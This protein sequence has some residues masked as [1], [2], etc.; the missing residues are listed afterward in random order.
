MEKWFGSSAVCINENDELLMVLQGKSE[1]KKT[2]SI[3]SGGKDHHESFQECCMRE[4]EEE[5]GYIAEVMDELKVK[6]GRYDD[7]HISFEIHYF[8][9]KITGG[10][11]SIQDPDNL[12]HDIA[13]KNIAE[14]KSL[15]L[16]YPE[17]R[18]Y[19][20]TYITG[21]HRLSLRNRSDNLSEPKLIQ[22]NGM[23]K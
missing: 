14:L 5:T 6:T 2:W 12:I 17:D 20:V 18:D 19:L 8:S 13:W 1:E 10:K 7:L 11:R 15:D 23:R 4:M 9:V 3:P 21:E 22:N 16:T